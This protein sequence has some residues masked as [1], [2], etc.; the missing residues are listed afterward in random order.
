MEFEFP[1][2]DCCCCWRLEFNPA[3]NDSNMARNWCCVIAVAAAKPAANCDAWMA[4]LACNA[5]AI[6]GF[7]NIFGVPVAIP[8][9][10]NI[11]GVENAN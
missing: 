10:V 7:A 9:F 5:A 11:F 1:I 3:E 2:S 8:G 6:P 4:E